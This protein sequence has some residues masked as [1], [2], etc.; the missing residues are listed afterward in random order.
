MSGYKR[1]Y[2]PLSIE[3]FADALRNNP[4]PFQDFT[5][6]SDKAIISWAEN[7]PGYETYFKT[8]I[9]NPEPEF[10]N[11]FGELDI[12]PAHDPERAIGEMI[13]NPGYIRDYEEFK[14]SQDPNHL[15]YLGF[16]VEQMA[17]GMGSF[18]TG[19]LGIAR[20]P[21]NQKELLDFLSNED[22]YFGPFGLGMHLASGN[23]A[24]SAVVAKG[25]QLYSGL[26]KKVFNDELTD[27]D[28]A[29]YKSA[30]AASNEWLQVSNAYLEDA[31]NKAAEQMES[32]P[33]LRGYFRWMMDEP[34]TSK[35]FYHKD[36]FAKAMATMAPSIA[37]ISTVSLATGGNLAAGIMAGFALEGSGMWQEGMN[38]Y[39]EEGLPVKDENGNFVID[40]KTG[41]PMRET[42]SFEEALP[43]VGQTAL[44][45]GALSAPLEAFQI[46]RATRLLNIPREAR[47]SFLLKIFDKAVKKAPTPVKG[48]LYVADFGVEVIEG[49]AI[50]WLQTVENMS[51]MKAMEMGYG[52]TPNEALNRLGKEIGFWVFGGNLEKNMFSEEIGMSQEATEAFWIGLLGEAGY[53]AIG[54]TGKGLYNKW[55]GR[56]AESFFNKTYNFGTRSG[57][58]T[59][60]ENPAPLANPI[61]FDSMEN[62]PISN[63]TMATNPEQ[64]VV[65]YANMLINQATQGNQYSNSPINKLLWNFTAGG[66]VS[67]GTP[68]DDQIN[69]IIRRGTGRDLETKPAAKAY[70]LIKSLEDNPDLRSK[71]IDT[72]LQS[73][74]LTS[75]VAQIQKEAL[76]KD[77]PKKA[78]GSVAN[79]SEAENVIRDIDD[80]DLI[81]QID[82]VQ[83]LAN[84]ALQEQ[85]ID[86]AIKQQA[87]K[88]FESEDTIDD[89]SDQM[90]KDF[91]ED[92]D[93]DYA[94][95]LAA[96]NEAGLKGTDKQKIRKYREL[97][98][99]ANKIDVKQN[100]NKVKDPGKF[101][102]DVQN[103]SGSDSVSKILNATGKNRVTNTTLNKLQKAILPKT[104]QIPAKEIEQNKRG[105]IDK[106][107]TAVLNKGATTKPVATKKKKVSIPKKKKVKAIAKKK[108]LKQKE[109]IPSTGKIPVFRDGKKSI[110]DV[111]KATDNVASAINLARMEGLGGIS[112]PD[113]KQQAEIDEYEASDTLIVPGNQVGLIKQMQQ[114]NVPGSE[115]ILITKQGNMDDWDMADN[116]IKDF[117]KANFKYIRYNQE[118]MP[119]KGVDFHDLKDNKFYGTEP[120]ISEQ[121]KKQRKARDKKRETAPVKPTEEDI[122]MAQVM[123]LSVSDYMKT[124]EKAPDTTKKK[125]PTTTETIEAKIDNIIGDPQIKGKNKKS[126][127][128]IE[129]NL[130]QK[131][132]Q[133]NKTQEELDSLSDEV[134]NKLDDDLCL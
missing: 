81:S 103:Q 2:K 86:I 16:N 113:P 112:S 67:T 1:S 133:Q 114:M 85:N 96:A 14:A 29:N 38:L 109:V 30:K 99:K 42:M 4:P 39:T 90:Q 46:G 31:R 35:N 88:K 87:E 36:Q 134:S 105:L 58:E 47:K 54:A 121:Y 20:N 44:I 48:A 52:D 57:K 33:E 21:D 70:D 27:K 110:I 60:T 65:G 62:D 28:N 91:E 10:I 80:V 24:K 82:K 101:L 61:D 124:L 116:F 40:P 9:P 115:K 69:E 55:K 111:K 8:H 7:Q 22:T 32:D 11:E 120:K 71:V 66:P 26:L 84:E 104:A 23:A 34:M 5:I 106:L 50:E 56:K 118:Q 78:R 15:K 49:G 92:Y 95:D 59:Q 17:Y 94:V 64:A 74:L 75:G 102:Q 73:E 12:D 83:E 72:I 43:F 41:E 117:F 6:S 108:A 122:A 119:E 89:V 51:A 132:E 131:E 25:F 19:G 76:I 107:K 123:G 77:L 125:K 63:V 93:S 13:E 18:I 45:Y 98:E 100:I 126:L 130:K 3:S 68:M 53:G 97:L 127:D 79:P 129:S 128:Q 37:T